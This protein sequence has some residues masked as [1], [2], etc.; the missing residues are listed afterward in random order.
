VIKETE[1]EGNVLHTVQY[2]GNHTGHVIIIDETFQYNPQTTG[3]SCQH[4]S[5]RPTNAHV[6][7]LKV[8]R[9]IS[10]LM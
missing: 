1:A 2:D 5:T 10:F 9:L 6:P 7:G 3:Q 8:K 4:K